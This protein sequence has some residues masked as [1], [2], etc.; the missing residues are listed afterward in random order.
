MIP[1]SLVPYVPVAEPVEGDV[2]EEISERLMAYLAEVTRC[3]EP[4][5]GEFE[6][7]TAACANC[8]ELRGAVTIQLAAPAWATQEEIQILTQYA[9]PSKCAACHAVV[10]GVGTPVAVLCT[11]CH[12]CG[13]A[14]G[15]DLITEG[16]TET[17]QC[18][19]CASEILQSTR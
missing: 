7:V 6:S 10:G 5:K 9:A 13:A 3:Y 8:G 2:E 1:A 17:V 19:G 15:A 16:N 12:Q 18:R 14:A 4:V 11:P